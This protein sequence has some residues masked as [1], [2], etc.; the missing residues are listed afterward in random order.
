MH[1]YTQLYFPYTDGEDYSTNGGLFTV[2]LPQGQ[3]SVCFNIPIIDDGIPESTETFLIFLNNVNPGVD[4]SASTSTVQIIDDD[5][6]FFVS[7]L[8]HVHNF[9]YYV[10]HLFSHSYRSCGAKL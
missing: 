3:S 8:P 9:I 1:A 5:G 4:S 10:C 6:K 2:I 7:S